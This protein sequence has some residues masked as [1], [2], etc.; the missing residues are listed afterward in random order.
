MYRLLAAVEQE[1]R[2]TAV[3]ADD[4]KRCRLC[5]TCYVVQPIGSVTGMTTAQ[6]PTSSQSAQTLRSYS[7]KNRRYV[8]NPILFACSYS[9][10]RD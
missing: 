2:D 1:A 4:L 6:K 8:T 7:R 3:T 10:Q 5:G 9:R